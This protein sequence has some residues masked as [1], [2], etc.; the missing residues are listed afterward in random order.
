MQV[1]K[2]GGRER[3][4][5]AEGP[6]FRQFG[7]T[8]GLEPVH[9]RLAKL[10]LGCQGARVGAGRAVCACAIATFSFPI[11]SLVRDGCGHWLLLLNL[12]VH[13]SQKL[14]MEATEQVLLNQWFL[15]L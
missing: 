6:G 14:P 5:V 4:H 11:S 1:G 15:L 8:V 2:T 3:F 7:F 10:L 13:S 9:R 12:T